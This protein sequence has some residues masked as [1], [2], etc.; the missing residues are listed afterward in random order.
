MG[1]KL[2]RCLVCLLAACL[3]LSGS[4]ALTE[5]EI[6]T[7]EAPIEAALPVEAEAASLAEAAPLDAPAAPAEPAPLTEPAE[8]AAEAA[9]EPE[10]SEAALPEDA[11]TA[12][13]A[14]EPAEADPEA[15]EL[16]AVEADP[17]EAPAE[18]ESEEVPDAPA[19]EA[20]LEEETAVEEPAYAA[21]ES[22]DGLATQVVILVNEVRAENGLAP[23]GID[24]DLV[25]AALIRGEEITRVFSHTRPDGTSCATVSDKLYGENIAYGQRSAQEVMTDW[26]N[27]EG[28][29][30]NILDPRFTSIGV[31][32][33]RQG[34]ILYWVQLFGIDPNA[35]PAPTATPTPTATVQPT[36]TPSP[37]PAPHEHDFVDG[38][39]T[40]CGYACPHEN[41]WHS[42]GGY[43]STKYTDTGS[44][45]KH[46]A[47]VTV[48]SDIEICA[49][50]D[51]W[52][53]STPSE[54]VTGL[55]WHDYEERDGQ[56]VCVKCGHVNTCPH[57]KV[58]ILAVGTTYEDFGDNLN[59]RVTFRKG[60]EVQDGWCEDCG[61]DF[62]DTTLKEDYTQVET[63]SYSYDVNDNGICE[64][65][66]HVNTCTHPNVKSE[67][68]GAVVFDTGDDTYHYLYEGLT[69]LAGDLVEYCPDC[70]KEFDYSFL[71]TGKYPIAHTYDENGVCTECGHVRAQQQE[72]GNKYEIDLSGVE[73][74]NNTSGTGTVKLVSGSQP[75]EGLYA[76]VTWVYTLSNGDSFAYCAMKKVEVSDSS[77]TFKMVSPKAPYGATL[78]SVQVA[79]VTDPEAD[80]KGSYDALATG[81]K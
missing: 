48:M 46:L 39:C 21:G 34:G 13:E 58:F 18:A 70:G 79:L 31:C 66:G 59:H 37:M 69:D 61:L 57:E 22:M 53:N 47:E 74:T 4:M 17:E 24:S 62:S 30:A 52:V 55:F 64:D 63:H 2:M 26:M 50:C 65:C 12:L 43:T 77:I 56:Y 6:E 67:Y 16:P 73:K 32:V 11:Y 60:T 51:T 44:N 45:A 3:V 71:E 19:E 80:A 14:P 81:R 23:L 1:K 75:V 33:W 10:E 25:S 20:E 7:N 49:D 54:N 78:D 41:T 8:P 28:H 40:E 38:I 29:R 27:S 36:A 35:A 68:F 5:T 42:S 76:R 9:A 15:V 72:T